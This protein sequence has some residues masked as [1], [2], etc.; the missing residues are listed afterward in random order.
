[1]AQ[2]PL[3]LNTSRHPAALPGSCTRLSL[4]GAHLK[5]EAHFL[6]IAALVLQHAGDQCLVK[7]R[8]LRRQHR[9]IRRRC[10]IG[11][12]CYAI[13]RCRCCAIGCWRAGGCVACCGTV[14]G[15]DGQCCS[16]SS[17]YSSERSSRRCTKAE[18]VQRSLA[19][20]RVPPLPKREINKVQ[21]GLKDK[22][23]ES[24]YSKWVVILDC[25]DLALLQVLKY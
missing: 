12:R 7:A 22:R 8:N 16:W 13:G 17:E 21:P 9:R 23:V 10:A 2:H 15:A 3:V 20:C 5:V 25:T 6:H 19:D 18:V 14:C 24:D 11:W 4:E 1:M